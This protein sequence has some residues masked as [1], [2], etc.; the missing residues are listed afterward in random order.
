MSAHAVS[1]QSAAP[2]FSGAVLADLERAF[3][4]PVPEPARQAARH[5]SADMVLLVRARGEA[6]FFTAMTRGQI[7]T[8][9][10]RRRDGSFYPALLTDLALY[11]RHRRAWRRVAASLAAELLPPQRMEGVDASVP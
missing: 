2:P 6:A 5:G 11:H 7:V 8:I 4:G 1:H 9:R 3:N 10:E